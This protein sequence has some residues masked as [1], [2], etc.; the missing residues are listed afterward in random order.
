MQKSRIIKFFIENRLL[1]QF[2]VENKFPQTAVLG[3][4][5]LGT[6]NTLIHKTFY[7]FDKWWEN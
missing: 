5:Y 2:E 3:N 1:W 6:N 4:I 7:V